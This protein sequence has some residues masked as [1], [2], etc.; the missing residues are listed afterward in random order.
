MNVE[1]SSKQRQREAEMQRR[2]EA[3]ER[4]E[5]SEWVVGCL[6]A[7]SGTPLK[8][9]DEDEIVEWHQRINHQP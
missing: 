1:G 6:R 4:W 8:E 5:E 2:V 3:F 9:L 7:K